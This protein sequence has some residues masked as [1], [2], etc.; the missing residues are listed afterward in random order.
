MNLE[1][2][3][4]FC[5]DLPGVIEELPF[6]PDT[7]VFKVM[8]KVFLLTPMDSAKPQFNAKCNPEKAEELREK[9]SDI[10]PG[11]HMNKKHWN[12]V[13]ITG[14]IPSELLYGLIKDS[15]ELVVDSLPKKD[16]A[17]LK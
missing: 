1:S 6:G 8:G 13:L 9:Y 3:R 16:K 2:I 4:D 11:Y 7:L 14:S 17:A 15:Y 12:T 10:Q 5:L